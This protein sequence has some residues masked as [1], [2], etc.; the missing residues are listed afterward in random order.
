MKQFKMLMLTSMIILF[1]ACGEGSPSSNK[2]I[3]Y[4]GDRSAKVVTKEAKITGLYVA[5]FNRAADQ[6]GLK[7]WT[8]K[9]DEVAKAG[10]DVSSVFKKLSGGFATHPVFKSTYDHLNNREFVS[11]IYRNALGRDG[12]AEGIDYWTKKLDVE[13]MIRSDIVSDFIELSLVTDLTPENYPNLSAEELAAG[14]LRQ[15]L[16]TNKATVALNFTNQLGIL[17]NVVDSQDPEGD[18]AYLASIKIISEVTEE[19]ETVSG[20]LDFLASIKESD[21]PI[22]GILEVGTIVPVSLTLVSVLDDD[23]RETSGLAN[24]NG[25]IYT[26]N[27]YGGSELL[28]EINATTGD[29]IRSIVVNGATNV[30]WEDLADDG[31][32]LYIADIGNN[33]GYRTDLKIYK[34]LKNDLNANNLVNVEI[35][36]FSYADQTKFAY[37]PFTT[38]YDAEALIAY[39]GQLYIF[40]KN[41]EDYTSKI[42][43]IPTVP[44]HYEVTSVGEKALDVMITGAASDRAGRS[45]ALVGYTNPYDKD[46]P[47]K[48]MIVKLSGFS[49]DDFFSGIIAEHKIENSQVIGQIEAILFNAPAQFYLSAE[50]V[51]IKFIELPAKLY[52]IES[53]KLNSH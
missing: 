23:I 30:D 50:G 9:A 37:E 26:H 40:T 20:T 4:V 2:N 19:P 51:S 13:G 7:Y 22:R 35:I 44:G 15:D 28:Y 24:V 45:V 33:L 5:Y 11:L 3:G 52:T 32:Y 38:P 36:S 6:E 17:S 10:D 53:I 27:D 8:D 31:T 21:D 29:V 42:Y 18:P 34:I 48:S 25:R 49:G 12:D 39:N 41:W 16:I 47:F 14:Q 1:T 43:S 46:T